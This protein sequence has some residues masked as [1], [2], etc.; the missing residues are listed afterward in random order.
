[1][2]SI[3]TAATVAEYTQ[4]LCRVTQTSEEDGFKLNSISRMNPTLLVQQSWRV[5]AGKLPSFGPGPAWS[6]LGRFSTRV[7][8]DFTKMA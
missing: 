5:V 1:M 2:S 3:R 8:S 4:E 7:N 6:D